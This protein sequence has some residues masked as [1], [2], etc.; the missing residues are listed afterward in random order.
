MVNETIQPCIKNTVIN[1]RL[2]HGKR[3][4]STPA[5]LLLFPW[6]DKMKN[7]EKEGVF[8]CILHLQVLYSCN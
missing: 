7:F 8:C 1:N 3:T 5:G 2:I 6:K 4:G